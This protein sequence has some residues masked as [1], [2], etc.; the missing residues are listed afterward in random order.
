MIADWLF[1]PVVLQNQ[2]NHV[3]DFSIEFDLIEGV[4]L[5]STQRC[6]LSDPEASLV[7][8]ALH[9]HF[10]LLSAALLIGSLMVMLTQRNYTTFICRYQGCLCLI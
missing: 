10:L 6:N 5:S 4:H 9:I 1:T 2:H 7:D 8:R 3:G